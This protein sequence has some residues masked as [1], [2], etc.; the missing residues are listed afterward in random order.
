[1]RRGAPCT[2]V[3][4]VVSLPNKFAM[5]S[6]C[7]TLFSVHVFVICECLCGVAQ[8]GK[9]LMHLVRALVFLVCPLEHFTGISS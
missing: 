9:D 1:M 2:L 7:A 5:H 4:A 3:N 6:A 8:F